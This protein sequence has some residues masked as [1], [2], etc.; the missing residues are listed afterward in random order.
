MKIST[1]EQL[2]AHVEYS[3]LK[4]IEKVEK[5]LNRTRFLPA[6]LFLIGLL[7]FFYIGF[8][9]ASHLNVI[10]LLLMT[11]VAAVGQNNIQ[12]VALLK[13]LFE[14]KYGK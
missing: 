1:K 9:V 2:D 12:R 7:Y 6:V 10:V 5:K 4:N 3:H 8:D 11:M 13:E 14:L